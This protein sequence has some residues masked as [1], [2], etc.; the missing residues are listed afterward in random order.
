MKRAEKLFIGCCQESGEVFSCGTGKKRDS[1]TESFI[2][3]KLLSCDQVG[4]IPFGCRDDR[5]VDAKTSGAIATA[6]MRLGFCHSSGKKR[7][8][9][10]N[11]DLFM[12]GQ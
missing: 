10:K 2:P 4:S 5:A 6:G 3:E 9:G 12:A 11:T 7:P 8:S 1:R